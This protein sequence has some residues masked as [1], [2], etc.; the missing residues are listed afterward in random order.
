M[1]KHRH[2]RFRPVWAALRVDD[3]LDSGLAAEEKVTVKEV[4][5][6]E[7]EADAAVA[8]LNALR[9]DDGSRYLVRYARVARE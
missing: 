7:D 9:E 6:T 8:R 3:Y 1:S 4:W 2:E 5:L